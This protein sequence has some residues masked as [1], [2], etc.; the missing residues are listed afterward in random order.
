MSGREAID[1]ELTMK[2][3]AVS[4]LPAVITGELVAITEDGCTPLVVFPG[5]QG[6]AAVRAGTVVD[7]R[8]Q[9]I[10]QPVVLVFDGGDPA[11]PIVVGVLRGSSGWPLADAP[12]EVQ[13]DVDGERML[14][15][16]KEELVM[17]CGR[18]SITLT[19]SGKV[20]IRGTHVVSRSSGVNRLKGGAVLLN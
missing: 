4:L 20:V 1:Q 19:R 2:M 16:A 17:R 12:G 9:H 5:Q 13:V 11:R 14:V 8:G 10:G 7:L 15:S 3:R 6:S 18:A